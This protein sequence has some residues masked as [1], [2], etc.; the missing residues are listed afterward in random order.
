MNYSVDHF[1]SKFLAIPE[2]MWGEGMFGKEKKCAAGHCGIRHESDFNANSEAKALVDLFLTLNI[3]SHG[4]FY[5]NILFDTV[6]A[7][8]DGH[9]VNYPQPTPKQ[10]ILAALY[11]I[12]RMQEPVIE[13]KTITKYVAVSPT[14][15]EQSKEVV[16][17]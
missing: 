1:I 3:K 6:V 16:L 9:A 11:D 15:R 5:K 8:N 2:E 17:S 12:K 4:H 10:R 14:L 7:V 13:V